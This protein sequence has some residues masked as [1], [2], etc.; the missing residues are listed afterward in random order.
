[1][2]IKYKNLIL[3]YKIYSKD[4]YYNCLQSDRSLYVVA[5]YCNLHECAILEHSIEKRYYVYNGP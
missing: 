2:Y 1:M 4:I 5:I 3:K